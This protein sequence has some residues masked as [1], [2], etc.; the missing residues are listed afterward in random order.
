M[1]RAALHTLGWDRG[2]DYRRDVLA[3]PGISGHRVRG[4]DLRAL[5]FAVKTWEETPEEVQARL[6]LGD[7]AAAL[8]RRLPQA[9]QVLG[10]GFEEI[11]DWLQ[12]KGPEWVE[13]YIN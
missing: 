6:M 11:D 5:L 2:E 1:R 10:R 8:L 12:A 7:S 3:D 13:D 9:R 4:Q